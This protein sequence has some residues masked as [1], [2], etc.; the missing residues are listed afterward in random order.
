MTREQVLAK[1]P[2]FLRKRIEL[3]CDYIEA[4]RPI[5]GVGSS[6]ADSPSGQGRSV[7]VDPI[8]T[9]SPFDG[10]RVYDTD[11]STVLR[12][13]FVI[14]LPVDDAEPP[15][16]EDFALYKIEWCSGTTKHR[17]VF[18]SEIIDP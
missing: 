7:N 18:M 9:P 11:E 5:S 13:G 8:V 2:A 14:T 6:I 17:F 3:V 16:T 12:T 15:E 4:N 10:I 1:C